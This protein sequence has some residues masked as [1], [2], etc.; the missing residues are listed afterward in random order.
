MER[1]KA[2]KKKT[3]L[4]R[5]KIVKIIGRPF[6]KE[7]GDGIYWVRVKVVGVRSKIA[8]QIKLPVANPHIANSLKRG[9]WIEVEVYE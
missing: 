4:I 3:K 5:Y 6:Q 9:E 7:L 2:E 1:L 8:K